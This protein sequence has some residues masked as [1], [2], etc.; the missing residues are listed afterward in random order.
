MNTATG[1]AHQMKLNLQGIF[2]TSSSVKALLGFKA[3]IHWV[4]E[5]AKVE[6]FKYFLNPMLKLATSI[7]KHLQGI[8]ARWR[9]GTNNGILEG[10]N[11]V[12]S[13]VKRQARGFKAPEYLKW[14]LYIT[15]GKLPSIPYLIPNK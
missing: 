12:F 2:R 11:S 13:A 4:K 7:E 9:H 8:M 6:D 5:E 1:K 10:I 15:A 14:M 3:W